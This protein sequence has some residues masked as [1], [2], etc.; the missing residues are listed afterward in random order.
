MG[1]THGFEPAQRY[2]PMSYHNGSVWPHDNALIALGFARYGHKGAIEPVFKGMFEAAAY[3]DLRRLPE[4]F[5]GFQRRRGRGPTL[6][7]VACSPQVWASGTLLLML[8]AR[9][10]SSL[11]LCGVR[12]CFRDPRLPGFHRLGSI[13]KSAFERVQRRCKGLPSYRESLGRSYTRGRNEVAFSV[14]DGHATN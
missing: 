7:P 8:Q 13:E 14:V 11:T 3:M 12:S 4:L 1:Y 9:W 6:Y 5:C 2:N 10:D